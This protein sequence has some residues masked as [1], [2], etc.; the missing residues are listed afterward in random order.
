MNTYFQYFIGGFSGYASYLFYEITHPSWHNYFYALIVISLI[1][2]VLEWCFPWRTK[3]AKIRSD[4]YLDAFYMFFNFFL[5]SLI[6][7]NA[8]SNV[9]VKLF[10]DVYTWLGIQSLVVINVSGLH[11]FLQLLIL[12]V[13]R[14]FIQWNIH[15]LLHYNSR[16]WEFHK[17]HHSV[18]EMGFAAHLR[19]HFAE[20]IIYRFLEYIPLAMIGFGLQDFFIVHIFTLSWGHFNHANICVPLGKL[21]YIFNSPQMH[22]WHHAKH[23]PKQYKHGVNYG[24]TLSVWDYLFNTAYTPASK[25]DIQLGFDGVEDFPK[26]FIAQNM[27]GFNKH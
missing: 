2:M 24:L 1:F 18:I 7:Y 15:R 25:P 4:F 9:V 6:I 16:L 11:P 27:Q 26:T 20:N 23:L 14:D 5:F 8:I 17:V 10:I 22:L 13:V 3:Q 21:R 12:F 19:Y